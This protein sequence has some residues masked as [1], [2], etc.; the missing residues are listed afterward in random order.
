MKRKLSLFLA[1]SMAMGSTAT[2]SATELE[3]N[4]SDWAKDSINQWIDYGIISGYEYDTLVPSEKI[5]RAEYLTL[6]D[7]LMRYEEITPELGIKTFTDV[8]NSDWYAGSI[9]RNVV[10]GNINGYESDTFN[11]NKTLTRETAVVILCNALDIS[12][13]DGDTD[14]EDDNEISEWAKPSVKAFEQQDYVNGRADNIFAPQDEITIA[15]VISLLDKTIDEVYSNAGTYSS[16]VNGNVLINTEDVILKDCT[17][18]G[19]LFIS[20]GVKNGNVTLDNVQVTGSVIVEGGGLDS[21][22]FIN[23]SNIHNI[24]SE[25]N[26]STPVRIY[27]DDTSSVDTLSTQ[28]SNVKLDGL[29]NFNVVNTNNDVEVTENTTIDNLI[30]NGGSL[31]NNGNIKKSTINS[32]ANN[33]SITGD[34]T[35]EKLYVNANGAN[36]DTAVNSLILADDTL[37]ITTSDKVKNIYV[38]DTQIKGNEKTSSSNSNSTTE[39]DKDGPI[40]SNIV[41]SGVTSSSAIIQFNSDE[42]GTYKYTATAENSNISSGSAITSSSAINN[43]TNNDVVLTGSGNISTGPN[44]IRLKN[45]ENN[46]TYKVKIK[47]T[48]NYSNSTETTVTVNTSIDTTPPKVDLVYLYPTENSFE[49]AFDFSDYGTVNFS[50]S[51]TDSSNAIYKFDRIPINYVNSNI[52]FS[53]SNNLKN[54][55]NYTYTIEATDLSGNQSTLTGAFETLENNTDVDTTINPPILYDFKTVST[56]KDSI[57]ISFMSTE[58]CKEAW[59]FIGKDDYYI[60]PDEQAYF[61]INKGYNEIE[62]P[63]TNINNVIGRYWSFWGNAVDDDG[64]GNRDFYYY[65]K[66]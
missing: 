12:P 55:T 38:G 11:P 35:I 47:T 24:T 63:S 48:N 20:S 58:D 54:G 42:D 15:E 9:Y 46:T 4:S 37:E 10:A 49:I 6:I 64:Y 1:I 33:T 32:T 52:E 41:V 8:S 44:K 56:N 17:I 53:S 14:F 66:L 60:T 39:T 51:E 45:L 27:L 62:I 28:G 26:S 25:K 7:K 18:N 31:T 50:T 30:I 65:V 40:I 61:E 43:K 23:G 34:G 2:V 36:I 19:N 5:T 3:H 16:N 21:I 59:Y 22:E 29:G 57:L 13:V